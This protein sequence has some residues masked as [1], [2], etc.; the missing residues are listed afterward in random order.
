MNLKKSAPPPPRPVLRAA[1]IGPAEL[2]LEVAATDVHFE[3]HARPRVPEPQRG[4]LV[5]LLSAVVTVLTGLGEALYFYLAFRVDPLR[6]LPTNFSLDTGIRP[7]NAARVEV[8]T[9]WPRDI[10]RVAEVLR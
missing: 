3:A 7:V 5:A 10:E 6:V 4:Q 9:W 8:H 1:A 2:R